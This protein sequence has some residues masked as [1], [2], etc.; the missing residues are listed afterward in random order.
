MISWNIL[1][2]VEGYLLSCLFVGLY[3]TLCCLNWFA[4]K[5][6]KEGVSILAV[7]II[8]FHLAE[9]SE[10]IM[11]NSICKCLFEIWLMEFDHAYSFL[12]SHKYLCKRIF[13]SMGVFA[14]QHGLCSQLGIW[15]L[16]RNCSL[17]VHKKWRF[18]CSMHF[19]LRADQ[20]RNSVPGNSSS[21]W[22]SV[23]ANYKS[24]QQLCELCSNLI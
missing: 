12:C 10:Q 23:N 3:I 16:C 8:V 11:Q 24:L 9:K 6:K 14:Y 2:V 7:K 18:W 17:P 19:R 1:P 13:V 15:C 22:D 21:P 5:K 20:M 4:L